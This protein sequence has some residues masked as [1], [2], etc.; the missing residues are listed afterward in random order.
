M[1]QTDRQTDGRTTCDRKTALCIIVHHAV[2]KPTEE[3]RAVAGNPRD[4]IVNFDVC[5]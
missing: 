3:S 2:T 1:L 4:A 5:S